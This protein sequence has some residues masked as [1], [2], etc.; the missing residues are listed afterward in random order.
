MRR[1]FRLKAATLHASCLPHFLRRRLQGVR[2]GARTLI[3]QEAVPAP[4]RDLRDAPT[5]A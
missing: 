1:T 5:R 4:C 2:D 3:R